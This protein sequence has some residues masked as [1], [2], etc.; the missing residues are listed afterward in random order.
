M[1]RK[2][3]IRSSYWDF[4]SSYGQ[5]IHYLLPKGVMID[6]LSVQIDTEN[7]A[8]AKHHIREYKYKIFL[9]DVFQGQAK[10]GDSVL[11]NNGTIEILK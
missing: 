7:I 4:K 6:D 9:D 5:N 8:I 1:D 11:F 3:I 2:I 10:P